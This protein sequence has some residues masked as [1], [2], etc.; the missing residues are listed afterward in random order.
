MGF[1]RAFWWIS[2]TDIGQFETLECGGGFRLVL[3]ILVQGF[4][5][6]LYADV[7]IGCNVADADGILDPISCEDESSRKIS[8][9]RVVGF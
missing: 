5:Q 4:R 1:Q 8:G 6:S 2:G 7:S 3:N 9:F